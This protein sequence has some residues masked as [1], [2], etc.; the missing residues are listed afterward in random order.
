M[1]ELDSIFEIWQHYSPFLHRP[2]MTREDFWKWMNALGFTESF[3]SE[4]ETMLIFMDYLEKIDLFFPVYTA[5]R[6]SEF[7]QKQL[8]TRN[9]IFFQS[10]SQDDLNEILKFYH[11]FQFFQLILYWDKYRCKFTKE[12]RFYYY[13]EKNKIRVNEEDQKKRKKL[14]SKIEKKELNWIKKSNKNLFESF[15]NNVDR[16]KNL[17][18]KEKKQQK[19]KNKEDLKAANKEVKAYMDNFYL[20]LIQL[21]WLSPDFLKVWIKLDALALFKDYIITPGGINVDFSLNVKVIND[22]QEKKEVFKKFN[23]WREKKKEDKEHFL[24]KKEQDTLKNLYSSIYRLFLHSSNNR[25]NCLEKWQDLLDMIPNNKLSEL[26]GNLNISINILSI[27][28]N[29]ERVSWYLL[30]Y[31]LILWPRDKEYEKPYCFLEDESEVIEFRRSTLAD[32][33]LFVSSPFILYV[34][35]ETERK[36]INEYFRIKRLWFPILVENI[37]GVDKTIQNLTI[38]RPIKERNYYFFLDYENSQN[39]KEKEVLIN[40]KG[41]FFFPDFITENFKPKEI[42]KLFVDWIKSIGGILEKEDSKVLKEKLVQCKKK[43][44]DLIQKKNKESNLNGYEKILINFSIN[45]YPELL[46]KV[47]PEIGLKK[48][49]K[50]PSKKKFI[51]KFKKIFTEE[52]ILPFVVESLKN[53]PERKGEKFAFEK[54]LTPF[55]DSINQY[56]HRNHILRYDL[57]F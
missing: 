30:G 45:K 17:T 33:G 43:S 11:P 3:L 40:N 28:R 27:L 41:A 9:I 2:L 18:K 8:R 24:T 57:D 5:K 34:E 32:F 1:S 16:S 46:A 42:L 23:E 51:P 6:G 49:P 26:Y 54:K 56:I 35:G 38:N 21:Y 29:L 14:V 4:K 47:Y 25:I 39:Y 48:D 20:N 10:P 36:I 50:Y 37:Q 19:R 15:N 55:Y 44:E 7:W 22:E 53:D 13:L 12:S 31:N 52:Y